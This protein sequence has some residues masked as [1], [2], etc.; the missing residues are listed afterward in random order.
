MTKLTLPYECKVDLTTRTLKNVVKC[1]K[2]NYK[3]FNMPIFA[4]MLCGQV[5]HTF[6]VQFV[7]K[8]RRESN[9]TT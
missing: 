7:N 2:N 1:E 9:S 5:Y 4:D 8:L 3:N 6:A